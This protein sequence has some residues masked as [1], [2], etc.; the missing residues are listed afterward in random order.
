MS[1]LLCIGHRG[2]SGSEPENTL[3]SVRRAIEIGVDGIEIDVQLADGELL[4]IHDSTVD[5]TT[6]GTGAVARKSFAALRA[7]DAG[8]GEQIP[9]LREVL[10]AVDRR[11]LINIELKGRHTAAAVRRLIEEFIARRGWRY[12][13]FLVSSFHRSELAL[14]ANKRIPLGLLMTR[15]PPLYYLFARRLR[16]WS[17]HVALRHVRGRFVD[18]AHARGFKVLVYTVNSAADIARMARLGADGI[19]SDFPERVRSVAAAP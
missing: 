6:N 17:V 13:D 18:D 7:L 9:T 12:E 2:A 16:A 3:R 10:E 15:P 1:S 8:A 11:C 14:L 19:F 4:V 5:R